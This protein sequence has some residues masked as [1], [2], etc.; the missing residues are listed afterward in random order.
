V[1]YLAPPKP[2]RGESRLVWGR[3]IK[4][5]MNLLDHSQ[6]LLWVLRRLVQGLYPN[7]PRNVEATVESAWRSDRQYGR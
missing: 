6:P 2:D 3:T 7:G 5:A 4:Q 1:G